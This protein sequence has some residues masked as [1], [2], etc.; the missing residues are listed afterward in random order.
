MCV[1]VCVC[2]LG[3]ASRGGADDEVHPPSPPP[4]QNT[5]RLG[6]R[7]GGGKR[8]GGGV[9]Q[10]EKRIG[11]GAG[12][13]ESERRGRKQTGEVRGV[14]GG[15]RRRE[16]VYF[17]ES[18]INFQF[19]T[20]CINTKVGWLTKTQLGERGLAQWLD[21]WTRNREVACSSPGRSG[22]RIFLTRVR[23]SFSYPFLPR[24]TPVARK[25]SM[26]HGSMVYTER[27]P[28]RQQ[29]H[30]APCTSSEPCNN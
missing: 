9:R 24:V 3:V 14:E 13:C 12:G 7:G 27:A 25:R 5:K 10:R 19:S 17:I 16:I 18:L 28:R 20:A 6:A 4:T 26:V 11:R 29:F 8:A 23:F 30:V 22:G 21:R 1:C 15:G 2:S